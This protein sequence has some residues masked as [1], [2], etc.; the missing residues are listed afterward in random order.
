MVLI[1]KLTALLLCIVVLTGV[2]TGCGKITAEET[3][4]VAET[5]AA[6]VTSAVTDTIPSIESTAA[7]TYETTKA[8]EL[9]SFKTK[10]SSSFLEETF[11]K[12]MCESWFSLVDAV[13]AGEDTFDCPN[14][15]IY[16]WVIAEFPK[17]CFPV[18]GEIVDIDNDVELSEIDGTARFKYK[19]SKEEA[20]RMI[21]DFELLV[22]DVMN[23][24]MN[25]KYTD[26]ENILSLYRFFEETYIYDYDT[27]DLLEAEPAKVNYTSAYRLLTQKT[28]ICCEIAEAYSYLLMQAGIDAS[29]VTSA[30][31]EWSIVKLGDHYYHVDPTFALGSGGSLAY[32]MM[33]D[34]QRC[35]TGDYKKSE[36]EYVSIYSPEF[37]LELPADDET[38]KDIWDGYISYFDP[39]TDTI[40]YDIYRNGYV[41]DREVFDYSGIDYSESDYSE[42][43]AA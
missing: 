16:M 24:S 4:T 21:N 26:F 6:A 36:F 28:G 30:K 17:V 18:L 34:D 29:V 11:G 41:V 42:S 20:A 43:E 14:G 13:L 1:K 8:R 15:H 9:Y 19:V 10:I 2:V 25:P 33:T 31:H 35:Y 32:F 39:E 3:S 7:E 12:A 23:K 40:G 5:T 38:F 37:P 22:E 27:A